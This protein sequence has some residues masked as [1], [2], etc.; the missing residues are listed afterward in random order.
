MNTDPA[1]VRTHRPT[2]RRPSPSCRARVAIAIA[3][4]ACF[5][6]AGA[7][8]WRWLSTFTP[9][10][11]KDLAALHE[12]IHSARLDGVK[13]VPVQDARFEAEFFEVRLKSGTLFVEPPI[14]GYSA[15]AFFVGEGTVRFAPEARKARQDLTFWLGKPS[16]D[17]EPIT[18]AYFFSLRGVPIL[19]QLGVRGEPTVPFASSEDYAEAKSALRQTGTMLLHAFLN[20]DGRSKDAAWVL[21]PP[22]SIRAKGSKSAYLLYSFNPDGADEVQL[23]AFGH[24]AVESALPHK[25]YFRAI[26]WCRART[27]RFAPHG[28][29]GQ[30]STK[31]AVGGGLRDAEEETAISFAPN[32]GTFALSLDLTPRMRVQSV[33]GPA[34]EPLRFVQ[35]GFLENDPNYDARIVVAFDRALPPNETTTVRVR[36]SGRL[37]EPW[38][39]YYWLADEDDWHPV[40]DD[41]QGADYELWLT[42]PKSKEGVAAGRL[43]EDEIVESQ[44]RYHF[45]TTRPHKRSTVY[46]GDFETAKGKADETDVEIFVSRG[47]R[48]VKNLGF[49]RTE[50]EN[51]VRVYNRLLRPLDLGQLRVT[52]TPTQ[53]GRGFEGLILLSQR[54]GFGGQT[55]GSDVFR[56]H[57]VAHQWWGNMVQ[58]KNWPEDRWLSESFAEFTAMEYYRIR[59]EDPKKTLDQIHQRWFTPLVRA[60]ETTYKTLTGEERTERSSEISPIIDGGGNVYT[61]G[62]LVLHMLRYLYR[63]QTG[64]DDAFWK[65][66]RDFLDANSRKQVTTADFTSFASRAL[67]S[68]LDSFWDQWLYRSEIPVVRW[69]HKVEPKNGKWL[70]AVDGEQVGTDF[71]LRIPVYV[72]FGGNRTVVRPLTLDGARGSLQLMLPEEPAEITLNDGDEALVELER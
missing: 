54:A 40:M 67:G 70:L 9:E 29:V 22:E 24:D 69:S 17:A 31:L 16:L 28:R 66:L 18:R 48:E 53:H 55:S 62:P 26:S 20:R 64:S 1:G 4:S 36:S 65:M 12:E 23:R 56:A 46:F 63:V 60:Q 2:R 42:V 37:F 7:A 61:K 52:A 21:F 10:S 59:F 5:A 33:T 34:G 72:H 19:D 51:M 47:S 30:Y 45:R 49:A 32:A 68:N 14:H 35:W 27:P 50:I 44:H 43:L 6:P 71:K 41:P 57:E 3:A 39:Q 15:G 8:D 11:A 58:P 38:Y 25:Y 13:G